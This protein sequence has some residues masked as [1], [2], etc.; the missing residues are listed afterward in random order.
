MEARHLLDIP[1]E[2]SLHSLLLDIHYI[3]TIETTTIIGGDDMTIII[4]IIYL[5]CT[6]SSVNATTSTTTITTNVT[7]IM[8]DNFV[9]TNM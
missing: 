4:V 6:S 2:T 1:V 9:F 3:C 7:S 5:D 8:I